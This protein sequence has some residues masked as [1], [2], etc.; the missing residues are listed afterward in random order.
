[1]DSNGNSMGEATTGFRIYDD[2]GQSYDNCYDSVQ[3]MIDEGINEEAIF[4]FVESRFYDSFHDS[5]V[6]KGIYLN[7]IWVNFSS[8]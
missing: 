1:M 5:V 2:Y 7:G 6:D 8:N 3:E 4:R